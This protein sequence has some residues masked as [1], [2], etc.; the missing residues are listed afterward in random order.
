ML[1]DVH[2]RKKEHIQANC[3]P[4]QKQP[5]T[6]LYKLS[7]YLCMVHAVQQPMFNILKF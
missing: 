5:D 6:I 1:F 3:L 4:R 7:K 2:V